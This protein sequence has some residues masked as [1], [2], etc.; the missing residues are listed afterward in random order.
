MKEKPAHNTKLLSF[1]PILAMLGQLEDVIGNLTGAQSPAKILALLVQLKNLLGCVGTIIEGYN[2]LVEKNSHLAK[3]NAKLKRLLKK[4]DNPHSPPRTRDKKVPTQQTDDSGE[5]KKKPGGQPKHRGTTTVLDPNY[6]CVG[7]FLE[8]CECGECMVKD[9]K[10][11]GEKRVIVDYKVEKRVTEYTPTSATCVGCGKERKGKYYN[12]RIRERSAVPAPPV[13]EPEVEVQVEPEQEAAAV[14]EVEVQEHTEPEVE[15]QVEPEQEAA[16]VAEVEVQEHTE[17]EVEVQVEP[18]QEAAAVAEV[19]VQ[20]HTEPEVEVQVEPE[21]EAAAVAEVEVQEHTE[22]E[23]EVQVEPEQEAAAVAEVEVQEHTEP[24]VEVQVE[25]EQEAAVT[26]QKTPVPQAPANSDLRR[27]EIIIPKFGMFGMTVI[28]AILTFWDSRSVIRRIG[29]ELEQVLG[30]DIGTGTTFNILERTAGYLAPE[31]TRIVQELLKSPYLHIDETVARIAGHQRYIWVVATKNMVLYFPST[32]HST[33][34][35]SMFSTYAGIVISDGYIVYRFFKRRQRCWAHLMREAR[36]L[37]KNLQ[38]PYAD[39][40]YFKLKDI[41]EMAKEKK[42]EGVGPEWHDAMN[43]KLG[44]LLSYYSRYE[45]LLPVINTIRNDRNVWF[46]FMLY[47][48]VDPT[49]NWAELLVREVVKQ[50]V[51]RQALR[52]MEGAEIF[53]AILSCMGTWRLSGLNVQRRLE[54]YLGA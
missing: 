42:A 39:N 17:P 1:V 3:E 29:L 19:E 26:A 8:K 50:R 23:V 30:I 13:A 52:T 11:D 20:E 4:Y 7:E 6:E 18:E 31:M 36:D 34:L 54:K 16:A 22:P 5:P 2:A 40:F 51:M 14:A 10:V 28:L 15:V 41:F 9:V 38:M 37:R 12:L 27:S 21:Q 43:A 33:R 45:D 25:P 32:R 47:S 46:T 44:R 24:E 35:L 48:Y 49:N 53:S